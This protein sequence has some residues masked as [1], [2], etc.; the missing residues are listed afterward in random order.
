MLLCLYA[1]ESKTDLL[2]ITYK[3]L[4]NILTCVETV[5]LTS[6]YSSTYPIDTLAIYA[7]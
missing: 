4:T 6:C 1:W 7:A 3:V 2:E 5:T